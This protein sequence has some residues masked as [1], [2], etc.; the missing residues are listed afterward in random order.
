MTLQRLQDVE[1]EIELCRL[2][3]R[4]AIKAAQRA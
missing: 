4:L 3:V 2:R 1:R